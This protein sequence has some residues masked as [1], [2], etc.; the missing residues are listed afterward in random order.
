[1]FLVRRHT[2]TIVGELMLTIR[3][4]LVMMFQYSRLPEAIEVTTSRSIQ[5]S[6]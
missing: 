1:M 2:Q 6:A 4:P 3:S 5:T